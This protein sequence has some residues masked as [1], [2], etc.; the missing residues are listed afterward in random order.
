MS[1]ECSGPEEVSSY[2]QYFILPKSRAQP[3]HHFQYDAANRR[4]WPIIQEVIVEIADGRLPWNIQIVDTPGL[5]DV[6]IHRFPMTRGWLAQCQEMWL[7]SDDTR[8]GRMQELLEDNAALLRDV[9]RVHLLM[10]KAEGILP[11]RGEHATPDAEEQRQEAEAVLMDI[12]Q[13]TELRSKDPPIDVRFTGHLRT[14]F[15]E[16]PTLPDDLKTLRDMSAEI[17]ELNDSLSERVEGICKSIRE[18]GLSKKELER[19]RQLV[20]SVFDWNHQIQELLRLPA[21]RE[22]LSEWSRQLS[23]LHYRTRQMI[24][25]ARGGSF[26]TCATLSRLSPVFSFVENREIDFRQEFVFRFIEPL[27]EKLRAMVA[28]LLK[29]IQGQYPGLKRAFFAL[30]RTVTT[31]IDQWIADAICWDNRFYMVDQLDT[32][33]QVVIEQIRSRVDC[34]LRPLLVQ[35]KEIQHRIRNPDLEHLPSCFW[36]IDMHLAFSIWGVRCYQ[37]LDPEDPYC[38][39]LSR[40]LGARD[41]LLGVAPSLRPLFEA[42][43]ADEM[44]GNLCAI[45]KVVKSGVSVVLHYMSEDMCIA[46]WMLQDEKSSASSTNAVPLMIKPEDYS[47]IEMIATNKF[48]YSF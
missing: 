21:E 36:E 34:C 37:M 8:F 45:A 26:R 9:P 29:D 41:A 38:D 27:E 43:F 24:C 33:Y 6:A 31:H 25:D 47:D 4:F 5:G 40:P 35:A 10:T 28:E 19:S 1:F 11:R 32:I 46:A 13:Q 3:P 14:N 30:F 42:D 20:K 44:S 2:L 16:A 23:Q 7:L 17:D 48:H 18:G 22:K 12:I 15:D 39:D